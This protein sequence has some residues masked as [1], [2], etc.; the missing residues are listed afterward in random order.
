M[1]RILII[2]SILVTT[3]SFCN[4]KNSKHESSEAS[5]QKDSL[6]LYGDWKITKFTAGTISEITEKDAQKYVGQ[7]VTLKPGFVIINSDTCNQPYFKTSIQNSD[8]YFYDN[9]RVDKATLK[10]KQDSIKLMEVGCKVPPKYSNENSSNFLYDFIVIDNNIMIVSFKGFY[11][12]L[13]RELK[14]F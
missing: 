2:S 3:V 7:I 4:N 14:A 13:E 8:K 1:N 12:Y 5:G 9:N 10:I 6:V 11:F